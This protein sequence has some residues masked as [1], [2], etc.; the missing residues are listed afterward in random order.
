MLKLISHRGN[1]NNS[2][3]RFENSIPQID[4][5]LSKGYEV[6]IDVWKLP[7]EDC[8]RLG[9][10]KPTMSQSVPLWYL[11]NPRLWL[12]CKNDEAWNFLSKV[13]SVNCFL[14]NDEDWVMTS[15][16]TIWVHS[17]WSP[18]TFKEQFFYEEMKMSSKNIVYTWFVDKQKRHFWKI[19]NLHYG[20]CS[21]FIETYYEK[22]NP[23]IFCNG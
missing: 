12:H 6:E 21:D 15:N 9:H 1:L 2:N 20:V 23:W 10:D 4:F 11:E 19:D 17:R 22:F 13:P 7:N 14:H 5:V 8:F 18:A 16:G 3:P